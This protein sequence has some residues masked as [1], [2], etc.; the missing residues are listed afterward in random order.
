SLAEPENPVRSC[1]QAPPFPGPNSPAI[2][3]SPCG[4]LSPPH[5]TRLSHQRSTHGEFLRGQ[6]LD[7][8]VPRHPTSAASG[9]LCRLVFGD[10]RDQ[11]G[12]C[13]PGDLVSVAGE[14]GAAPISPAQPQPLRSALPPLA[15]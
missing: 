15:V 12:E 3:P 1:P 5:G 6:R 10:R 2:S 9:Y 14:G 8:Q 7:F 11:L 13:V 4:G